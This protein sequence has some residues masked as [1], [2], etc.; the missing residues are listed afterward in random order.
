MKNYTRKPKA[1]MSNYLDWN[2]RNVAAGRRKEEKNNLN[3]RER[4]RLGSKIIISLSIFELIRTYVAWLS[5]MAG[6]A[7]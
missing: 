2:S 6:H 7:D 1:L 3:F 5:V 4:K